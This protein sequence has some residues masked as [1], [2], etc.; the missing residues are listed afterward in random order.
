ML[1]QGKESVD[2]INSIVEMRLFILPTIP[3]SRQVL[4]GML[5]TV[6][7]DRNSVP[8]IAGDTHATGLLIGYISR[9]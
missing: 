6:W 1:V 9:Q 2:M 5:P 7:M 3:R 8:R 4:P